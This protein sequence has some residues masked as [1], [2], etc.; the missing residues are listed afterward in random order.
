MK[1]DWTN[2][3]IARLNYLVDKMGRK[4]GI[5]KFAKESDRTVDSVRMKF[6]RM[7]KEHIVLDAENKAYNE[8]DLH[9]NETKAEFFKRLRDKIAMWFK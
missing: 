4:E 6:A 1:K 5:K 2:Q 7:Y 3:D 9:K 8:E